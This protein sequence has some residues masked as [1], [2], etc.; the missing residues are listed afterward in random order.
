MST[1]TIITNV[2]LLGI[3]FWVRWADTK[4]HNDLLK[5]MREQRR[6]YNVS[7]NA[8][9]DDFTNYQLRTDRELAELKRELETKTK[10]LE[11]QNNKFN[12]RID[13]NEKELP[14]IIGKVV[15]QI[16]FSQ[17]TINRQM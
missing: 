11:Y 9:G 8:L 7:I 10:Q 4:G 6:T 17:D 14:F 15:G 13:K 12:K 2:I 16:E 3:I 1:L 5:T